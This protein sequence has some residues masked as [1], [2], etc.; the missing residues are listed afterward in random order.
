MIISSHL[1]KV[2]GN[3]E[4]NWVKTRILIVLQRIRDQQGGIKLQESM[5]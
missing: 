2:V 5:V 3:V 4:C 1:T